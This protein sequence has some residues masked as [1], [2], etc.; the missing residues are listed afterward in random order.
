[1]IREVKIMSLN[2]LFAQKI[3]VVNV[4]LEQFRD[5]LVEQGVDCLQMQW[6]IPLY[7]DEKVENLLALFDD[8]DE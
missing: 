4:G 6:S 7:V 3:K 1:M 8:E 2:N 5:D